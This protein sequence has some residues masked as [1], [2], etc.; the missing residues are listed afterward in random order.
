MSHSEAKKISN[1]G[2]VIRSVGERTEELCIK[3]ISKEVPIKNIVVVKN[4]TPFSE[5]LKESYRKGIELG[6]DWTICI[7]AD[8]LPRSN[9]VSVLSEAIAKQDSN[10]FELQGRILDKFF[11]G[12][13][14]GGGHIYRTSLLPDALE[15]VPTAE[16][17]L[18][19]ETYTFKEMTEKGH[20]YVQID[21]ILA[22]HDFEQSYTDIFRKGFTHGLKHG[23]NV[24][25]LRSYWEKE[26]DHD[27]DFNVALMGLNAASK[28]NERLQLD[29]SE[30]VELIKEA[31]SDNNIIEKPAISLEE[32]LNNWV[33]TIIHNH[34]SP[35]EYFSY[36]QLINAQKRNFN[37]DDKLQKAYER[38]IQDDWYTVRRYC[39][40]TFFINE[41]ARLRPGLKVIDLGGIKT[42]K[43]GEFNINEYEFDVKYANIDPVDEPDYLCDVSSV[44]VDDCTFDV[45]ILGE[46]LE[47]VRNPEKVIQEALRIIKPGGTLLITTPFLFH[48]HSDPYDYGRYTYHWYETV[49]SELGV[50]Q[51]TI[52]PQGGFFHVMAGYLKLLRYNLRGSN[53]ISK[54]IYY[55]ILLRIIKPLLR[56]MKNWDNLPEVKNNVVLSGFATGFALRIVKL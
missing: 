51:Y 47:H 22:I 9:M 46:V 38:L 52:I 14:G 23:H 25:L 33:D 32:H 1:V 34:K 10:I 29:P 15:V 28:Y 24:P 53:P 40:D 26:K 2:V 18:R 7:D 54:S 56:N 42:N 6:L 27:M 31:F 5:A 12:A 45:S 16:V 20:P 17:S 49:L 3:L 36:L 11:G 50:T 19:P 13:R 21:D 8:V 44:P 30:T 55:F 48:Q 39:V 43:R 4:I 37:I 41:A 35:E